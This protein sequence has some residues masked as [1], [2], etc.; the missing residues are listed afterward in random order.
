MGR[1]YDQLS[2]KERIE[3]Y[4]LHADGKSLRFIAS[5]MSRSASTVS[6]ELQRNGKSCKNWP[7]GIYDPER[8]AKLAARRRGRGKPYKLEQRPELLQQVMA[9]LETGKSPGPFSFSFLPPQ[10]YPFPASQILCPEEGLSLS[11]HSLLP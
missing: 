9:L 11:F 1:S 4:R 10:A 2:L 6:R 5:A 8:A 3:I 7:E